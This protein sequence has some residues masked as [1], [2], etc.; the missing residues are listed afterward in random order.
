[1][2]KSLS[3]AVEGRLEQKTLIWNSGTQERDDLSRPVRELERLLKQPNDRGGMG[4][5]PER[6]IVSFGVSGF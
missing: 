6:S 1:V 2:G 4:V 5:D 3:L